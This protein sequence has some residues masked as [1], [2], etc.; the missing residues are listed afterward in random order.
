MDNTAG[1]MASLLS[2]GATC[3]LLGRTKKAIEWYTLVSIFACF[4][5]VNN[6]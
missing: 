6:M 2:L 3:E 4:H 5:A 1:E